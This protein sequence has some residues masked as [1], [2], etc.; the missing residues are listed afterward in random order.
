MALPNS[1]S[2]QSPIPA[3]RCGE[4]FGTLNVP[5]GLLSDRPPDITMTSSPLAPLAAWQPVQPPAQNSISPRA[6]SALPSPDQTVSGKGAGFV[7]N[8]AAATP[9]TIIAAP[10][11]SILVHAMPFSCRNPKAGTQGPQP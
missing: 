2:V 10:A 1:A 9:T 8:Q 11:P 4:I 7:R 5:K 6:R 3:S